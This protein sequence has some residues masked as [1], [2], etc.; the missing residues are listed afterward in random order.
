ML[1]SEAYQK[2]WRSSIKNGQMFHQCPECSGGKDEGGVLQPVAVCK[3]G[4]GRGA[5]VVG[6][7][8]LRGACKASAGLITGVRPGAQRSLFSK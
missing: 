3:D 5:T 6:G 8:A 2:G 1:K 4:G 7:D